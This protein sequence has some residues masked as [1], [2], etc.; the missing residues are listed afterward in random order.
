MRETVGQ[1]VRRKRLER[2]WSQKDLARRINMEDQGRIS[3]F[4]L[5]PT[6]KSDSPI[7]RA[8]ND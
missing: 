6:A 3:T 4:E 8:I 1:F 5:A 2:G 7:L